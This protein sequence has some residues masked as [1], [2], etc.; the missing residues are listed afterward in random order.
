MPRL[1]RIFE[2]C[3]CGRV[4]GW[5]V[6]G[7]LAALPVAA[8]PVSRVGTE[9]RANGYTQ[10]QQS[11]Q[12]VAMDRDGDFVVVWQS[13][14]Q[15]G[16]GAGVFGQRFNAAGVPQAVEFQVNAYTPAGEGLPQ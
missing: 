10:G 7:V 15:D 1:P 5:V 9:F 16:D 6:M 13:Y 14:G 12:A 11:Y 2:R 4:G 3:A 8:Q